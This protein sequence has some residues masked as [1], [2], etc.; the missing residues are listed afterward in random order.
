MSGLQRFL[1]QITESALLSCLEPN[2]IYFREEHEVGVPLVRAAI[3]RAVEGNLARFRFPVNRN[4]FLLGCL[5]YTESR[6]E[7]HL[8][9]GYGL[10]SG[11]TTKINSLH[12]VTGSVGSVKIPSAIAH[13]MWDH[14]GG[15]EANELIL[16]H[17]HPVNVL[18]LLLDNLPLASPADRMT[19][20]ARALNSVQI[21]R[22]ILGRGR[23]LFYLGENG[24]VK[25]F[26]LPSILSLLERISSR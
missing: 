1:R 14:Y 15:N 9:V 20:E 3:N 5:D 21:F 7:E 18:N 8:M 10:R 24:F 13:A 12:H 23:V 19:L 22:S 25:Q 16:F 2:P 17:N 11:S 4:S 6:A 26:R